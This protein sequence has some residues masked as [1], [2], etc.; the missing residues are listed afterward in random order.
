[1]DFLRHVTDL[2]PHVIALKDAGAISAPQR[3]DTSQ[4][5]T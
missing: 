2:H 4:K 5:S 1:M 3:A